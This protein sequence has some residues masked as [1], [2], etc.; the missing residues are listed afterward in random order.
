MFKYCYTCGKKYDA[1]ESACPECFAQLHTTEPHRL[2]KWRLCYEYYTE[3]RARNG[4][5]P[6]VTFDRYRQ[7]I[8][9]DEMEE[10]L[11][12]CKLL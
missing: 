12:I 9:Y 11:I 1:T 3:S 5:P 4:K 8:P 7:M 2:A 10:M 6:A